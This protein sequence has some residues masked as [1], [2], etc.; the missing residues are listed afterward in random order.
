VSVCIG[1]NFYDNNDKVLDVCGTCYQTFQAFLNG[2][3]K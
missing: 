1:P 2:E 3:F